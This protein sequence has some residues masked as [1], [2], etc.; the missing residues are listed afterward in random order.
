MVFSLNPAHVYTEWAGPQPGVE[1]VPKIPN[2]RCVNRYHHV[3]KSL[4][5]QNVFCLIVKFDDSH[6]QFLLVP[7][8]AMMTIS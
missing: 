4:M 8:V 7:S 5:L 6:C 1:K 3:G 2:P